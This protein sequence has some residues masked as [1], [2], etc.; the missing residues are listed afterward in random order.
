[1]AVTMGEQFKGMM[2]ISPYPLD[3]EQSLR[4]EL[5]LD[6]VPNWSWFLQEVPLVMILPLYVQTV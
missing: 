4:A 2:D 6:P 5:L 1:M 3:V